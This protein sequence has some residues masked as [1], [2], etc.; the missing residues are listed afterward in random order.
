[1]SNRTERTLS[2]IEQS[3]ADQAFELFSGLDAEQAS[4]VLAHVRDKLDEREHVDDRTYFSRG[5]AGPLGKLDCVLKTKVD[6]LTHTLFLQQCGMQRTDASSQIRNCVYA[7]V[8]GKS[9]DQ[10]VVEKVNH[11]AQ[12]TEALAKLIGPFGGPEFD[13]ADS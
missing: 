11:D 13:G 10:M 8:H 1:M 5:I 4:C 12:R 7:L 3:A 2:L 9:Y 6:E